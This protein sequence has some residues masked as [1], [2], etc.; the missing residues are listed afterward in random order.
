MNTEFI[1]RALAEVGPVHKGRILLVDD[2]PTMRLFME[3][4]LLKQNYAVTTAANVKEAQEQF[5]SQG[6][7]TFDCIVTDYL[8]PDQTGL[9]LLRWVSGR[10]ACLGVI[11]VTAESERGIVA[12][13][14]RDG[15]CGFL[16]KPVTPG[17]FYTTVERAVAAT[18]H[19]R[20][21]AATE[22]EIKEVARV[23]HRMLDAEKDQR[24]CKPEIDMFFRPKSEAGGDF[25][26]H[27]AIGAHNHCVLL[28]DVSGHDLKA[29]FISAYFQGIVRG[30]LERDAPITQVL[31]FFNSF[32]LREWNSE[33]ANS[34]TS[35]VSASVAVGSVLI[36]SK[37]KRA[38]VLTSGSPLP[39]YL[40]ADGR[41]KIVGE[42]G[43][44]P[45][46]WF[47]DNPVKAVT[48]P[49][50][51][52][53]A[54]FMWTDGL[55]SF[56]EEQQISAPALASLLLLAE[57]NL[58]TVPDFSSQQDDI[59]ATRVALPDP[60]QQADGFLPLLVEQYNGSQLNQIDNLQVFWTRSLL[61]CL[62]EISPDDTFNIILA[63]REAVLNA[64]QHG[65]A[66]RE[67]KQAQFVL[68]YCPAKNLLRMFISD[69]GSGHHFDYEQHQ[70]IAA[71][72]L[73][74]KHRGL[75]MI[76]NLASQVT[77]ERDGADMILDFALDKLQ[78][79][80]L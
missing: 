77:M 76:H 58:R 79:A 3:A 32:L 8:M 40:A 55:E 47:P 34:K 18:R 48:L 46:G 52:G 22:A 62:P 43:S 19:K 41:G 78:P 4:L 73:I 30:M 71:N 64:L 80:I 42:P 75:V 65:C 72:E 37:E 38:T 12:D 59:L 2:E 69:E 20:R 14:L 74:D 51:D 1:K 67:D 68:S 13:S 63:A 45:L 57:H 50:E 61:F 29:A 33:Q 28:A 5:Q 44:A 25:L 60:D 17:V 56:A 24:S 16:D 23:Q 7:H 70:A 54:F 36:E 27:F 11:V 26:N 66:G 15:A 9:D 21:Q 31:E 53:G 10:D 6:G 49:I 39:V 35:A